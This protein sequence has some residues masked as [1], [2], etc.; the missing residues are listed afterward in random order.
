MDG[1]GACG[2]TARR[3][4]VPGAL[5]RWPIYAPGMTSTLYLFF[6]GD[7]AAAMTFYGEVLGGT[8][9]IMTFGQAPGA[10]GMGEEYDPDQ[11]MH[12]ELVIGDWKLMASDGATDATFE[13]FAVVFTSATVDRSREVFEALAD[14]GTID[15]PFEPSFFSPGFGLLTDKF[16][17]PWMIDTAQG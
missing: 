16:G 2:L 7:C 13:G 9:T 6:A 17:V 5:G 1:P 12:S 10:D 3:P 8:P 4:A 11:V 14:G 15:S